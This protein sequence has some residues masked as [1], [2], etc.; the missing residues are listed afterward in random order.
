MSQKVSIIS[1]M[2][3]ERDNFYDWAKDKP[4]STNFANL[5][6]PAHRRAPVDSGMP[7]GRMALLMVLA[8]VAVTAIKLFVL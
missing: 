4:D 3:T 8:A 5:N 6:R 1:Y 7:W 2:N